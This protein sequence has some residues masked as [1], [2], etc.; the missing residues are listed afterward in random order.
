MDAENI[1]Q[2]LDYV[3]RAVRGHE[4][5]PGVPAIYYLWALIIAVGWALPDFA[6]RTVA[7]YWII[8]SIG[9]GLASWWIGASDARRSGVRDK[10]IEARWG[11]H[12]LVGGI[13]FLVCWL[14]VLRGASMHVVAGNFLLVTGLVYALA[15]VHLERPLLWSGLLALVGYVVLAVVTVPYTWT[16]TGVIV[17]LAL[18]WAG[19]SAQRQRRIAAR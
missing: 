7:P 18:A 14:P 17:A 8:C 16:L 5:A 9:G 2:D 11:L 3:V 1:Q 6:P 10:A 19:V 15:G 4:A 12:F 13:G